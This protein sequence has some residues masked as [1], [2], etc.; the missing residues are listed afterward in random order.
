[1]LQTRGYFLFLVGSTILIVDLGFGVGGNGLPFT[2]VISVGLTPPRGPI[3]TA[4]PDFG[5]GMPDF[6][7]LDIEFNNFLKYIMLI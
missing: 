6:N 2:T 3:I 7:G 4:W 1:M 5:A